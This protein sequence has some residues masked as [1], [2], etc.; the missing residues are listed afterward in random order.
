VK[1]RIAIA[2]CSLFAGLS[3]PSLAGVAQNHGASLYECSGAKI[4][5]SASASEEEKKANQEE[6]RE[7]AK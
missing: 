6:S 1:K 7:P 5:K 3:L 4:A 2:V